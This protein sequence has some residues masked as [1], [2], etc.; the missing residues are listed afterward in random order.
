MAQQTPYVLGTGD[1]E[2]QRLGL[3]HRLWSDALQ[4]ACRRAQLRLGERVL[5]VGAGPGFASFDL[6][7]MVS[8]RGAVVAVDESQAFVEH[9]TQQAAAR[10]LAQLRGRRGDVQQLGA[11]LAAEAP[12]DLAYA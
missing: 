7:Q 12:F 8:D 11:L 10:G 2:L 3:Q 6:A 5:D 9:L 4:L 1:D